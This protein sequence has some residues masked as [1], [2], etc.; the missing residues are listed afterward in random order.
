MTT[1]PRRAPRATLATPA[2]PATPATLA[3]LATSATSATSAK[4]LRGGLIAL[5]AALAAAAVAALFAPAAH[6]EDSAAA[7]KLPAAPRAADPASR[8]I[9]VMYAMPA[10]H[11]RADGAYTGAYADPAGRAALRRAAGT[12]ARWRGTA[13]HSDRGAAAPGAGRGAR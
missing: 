10:L 5:L 3:T 1:A 11:A 4:L 2:T 9:L 8:Q 6:A 7:A 12:L 13:P